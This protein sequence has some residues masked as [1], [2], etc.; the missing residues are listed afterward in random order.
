MSEDTAPDGGL[1]LAQ[2]MFFLAR[3]QVT[4][5]ALM[6][7]QLYTSGAL[8]KDGA[9]AALELLAGSADED[10]ETV[11]ALGR[12]YA[13]ALRR[14]AAIIETGRLAGGPSLSVID[15][16]LAEREGDGD[17]SRT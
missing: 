12:E 5:T 9:V 2:A 1:D 14:H 6:A 8:T 15:G 3:Q 11:A 10:S 4:A 7:S 17:T 13:A 16:G